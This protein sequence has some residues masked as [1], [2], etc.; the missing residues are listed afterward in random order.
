MA[1]SRVPKSQRQYVTN[2]E[3]LRIAAKLDGVKG[4]PFPKFIEP[5]LASLRDRPPSG[6]AWV[7]EIKFD[8][9]RLQAHV[10]EGQ[11]RFFTRRGHDWTPRFKNL[12]E[13]LWYLPTH[14]AVIDGEVVV[15]T[16]KGLSDFG[17]L[18]EDLGSGRSDRLVFFG[19]DLLYLDGWDLRGCALIDRKRVLQALIGG[20]T[21]AVRYSEHLEEDG[22]RI[23]QNACRLQLEGIVSKRKGSR[24]ASGRM[25]N[26]TKVTCRKRETFVVAGIAY[27]GNK[28]DGVYLPRREG[29][30]AV[31]RRRHHRDEEQRRSSPRPV[32]PSVRPYAELGLRR[33]HGR[34][35]VAL[36]FLIS[37][38]PV[39]L[40]PL[41]SI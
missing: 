31:G 10:R 17:A 16:P 8:G 41:A 20:L 40:A 6:D 4:G 14:G 1:K 38:G 9:Y 2:S 29:D 23:Y 5:A 7:H 36:G 3:A 34:I 15:L 18:E 35:K 24:Y 33:S 19:F 39:A 32:G 26:W 13:P 22:N 21:G 12:Q 27:K 37:R 11:A 25:A 30:F 28:F